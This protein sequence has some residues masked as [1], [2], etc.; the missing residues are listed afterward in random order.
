MNPISLAAGVLPEYDAEVVADAAGE[1]GYPYAGFTI[2]PETWDAAR[3]RLVKERVAAHGIGV[4]DVEVVWILPGGALDDD[5]G[6]IIDAGAELGA[7]NV[8]V[9]SREPDVDRNAAALRRLCERASPSGM[10]VAIEFLMIAKVRSLSMAH[11]I[12]QACDHPAAAILIDTLH[13]QRAGEGVDGLKDLDPH[14]FPYAQLCDGNLDCEPEFNAYLEDALD[15]R[16]AAGE[17]E[18]PL[19][20]MLARLPADCPLSLEVRS[21][22]YRDDYPRPVDRARAIRERTEKFLSGA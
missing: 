17:G 8:L 2:N 22:R 13:Y 10:R 16:S 3:A 4:L 6:L 11:A 18:L 19:R 7:R 9:A 21:K 1:S 14:L 20:S 12:V 5:H 15:L